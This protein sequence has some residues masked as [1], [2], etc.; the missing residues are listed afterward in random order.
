[1]RKLKIYLET[2][3]W[4]FYFA[5]DSPENRD[6]TIEFFDSLAKGSYEIF[7][8]EVVLRE[9]AL[10]PEPKRKQLV[11]LV[12]RFSPKELEVTVDAEHLAEIYIEKGLV[13]QRKVEDALH[14]A[15]A[16]VGEMDAVI[17]WNYRHLANIRKSERFYSVNLEFG[18]TRLMQIVT[19]TGVMNDEN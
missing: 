12:T 1:M 3:V 16:C 4:N 15:V 13:P 17:S 2:S 19:P 8:S 6:I 10:A 18:Y 9:I 5:D 11:D 14:V 7:I